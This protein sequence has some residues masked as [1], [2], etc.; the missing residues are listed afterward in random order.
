MDVA[1][2]LQQLGLDR[3]EAAFRENDITAAVLPNLTAGDL[4]DLGVTSVGHR[5]Q[6]LQAIAVLRAMR[7]RPRHRM[8]LVI[9]EPRSDGSST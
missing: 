8:R 2:R 6:L 5:R 3:Y 1:D 9:S 7:S 4:K